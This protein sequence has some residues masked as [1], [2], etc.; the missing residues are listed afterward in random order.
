MRN[1][2]LVRD[3]ELDIAVVPLLRSLLDC[4]RS[5]H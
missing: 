5:T 3:F 1:S 2:I 4:S